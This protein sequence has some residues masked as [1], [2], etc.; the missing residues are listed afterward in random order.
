MLEYWLQSAI[1]SL[2]CGLQRTFGNGTVREQKGVVMK[3]Y[4]LALATIV[5]VCVGCNAGGVFNRHEPYAAPPAEMMLRP[6]PMVDG[7]GPG[8][9]PMMAGPVAPAAARYTQVRLLNPPGMQVGWQIPTGFAENQLTTPAKYD[10]LQGAT[11]RLKLTNVPGRPGLV[12]YPTLQVYPAHPTTDAYL[13]H[14]TVPI[15]LTDEDIDQVESNN[16]VTKVIYLPDPRFQDLAIAGADTLVSTQLDPG[17]D[18]VFEADRRGT[19]MAVLRVG[20]MNF[21]MPGRPPLPGAPGAIEANGGFIEQASYNVD[22]DE[23]HLVPPMPI[24][25]APG[26]M[27]AVPGPMMVGGF[28]APGYPAPHPV[29]GMGSIPSWGM[30][31]TG[32]PIGLAGPPHIPLGGPAGLQSHTVRNRTKVDIGRPVDHF[33]LDVKHKP[34]LKLPHP[35]KHVQYEERHPAYGQGRATWGGA[36]FGG[37]T[38]GAYCPPGQYP[39]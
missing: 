28:S 13:L 29:A 35:V 12:L 15:E 26:G 17:I 9:M 11:Y 20:N 27:H 16:F 39:Y 34:G 2:K 4:F 25:G 33:L 3:Y 36:G 22:G 30:P 5:V 18:P 7:P 19:I 37:A 10:F 21:E 31:I 32:T 6:G 38:G 1:D 8:V 23:G 24:G 14:N